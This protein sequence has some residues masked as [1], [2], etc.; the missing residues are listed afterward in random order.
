MLLLNI[1]MHAIKINTSI[2][3]YS[4]KIRLGYSIWKYFF[5]EFLYIQAIHKR[6]YNSLI[7]S[8]NFNALLWIVKILFEYVPNSD[9][10]ASKVELFTQNLRWI[11]LAFL[12]LKYRLWYVK[13][14]QAQSESPPVSV[15]PGYKDGCK[16][17]LFPILG[18]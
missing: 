6:H 12:H 16:R 18:G 7:A 9:N 11:F 14:S 13:T 15:P 4:G 17:Q 8:W 3:F 2:N 5:S 1:V 10:C